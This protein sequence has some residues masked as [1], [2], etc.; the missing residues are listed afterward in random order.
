MDI[1]IVTNKFKLF[2]QNIKISTRGPYRNTTS[3][4]HPGPKPPELM[5][6]GNHKP[7]FTAELSTER[8]KSFIDTPFPLPI[9]C[10]KLNLLKEQ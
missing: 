9:F 10:T 7:I 3:L 1:F 6:Q 2:L 8:I 5:K 4:D